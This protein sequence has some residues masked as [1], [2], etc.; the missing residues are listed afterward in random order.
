MSLILRTINEG[1]ED[2]VSNGNNV[3]FEKPIGRKGKK[4]EERWSL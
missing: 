1:E 3:E 4:K 2:N